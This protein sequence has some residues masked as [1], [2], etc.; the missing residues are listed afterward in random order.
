MQ[1]NP[2][3]HV[4]NISIICST[5][6]QIAKYTSWNTKFNYYLA[7]GVTAKHKRIMSVIVVQRKYIGNTVIIKWALKIQF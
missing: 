3:V 4:R 5:G 2:P 1:S 7:G 6:Y